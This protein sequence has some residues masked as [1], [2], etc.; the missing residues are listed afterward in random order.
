M[1][2]SGVSGSNSVELAEDLPN[3]FLATSIVNTCKPKQS[4]KYGTLLLRAYFAALIIP[5][6][7][8][9]PNPPGTTI[10]L[11]EP[12]YASGPSVSISSEP[13]QCIFTSCI[14]ESPA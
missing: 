7:P 9:G 3:K 11:T 14:N 5:S 12:K 13:T 4:P 2:G 1:T 10:P 6:T 8:L